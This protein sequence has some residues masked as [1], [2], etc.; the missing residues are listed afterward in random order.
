MSFTHGWALVFFSMLTSSSSSA[1]HSLSLLSAPF[2]HLHSI[3]FLSGRSLLALC[4]G[5]SH[6]WGSGS[7]GILLLPCS[8]A[9]G[10]SVGRLGERGI[11]QRR[12]ERDA[13]RY[14]K[15]SSS[16]YVM[17]LGELTGWGAESM[18]GLVFLVGS[19][20]LITPLPGNNGKRFIFVIGNCA[21][22]L[23][24]WAAPVIRAK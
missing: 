19:I 4:G 14:V 8:V 17:I 18:G 3:S 23:N 22:C 21:L 15:G 6:M 11:G 20:L 7:P 1:F 13:V 5:P 16:I 2:L 12:S 10:G 24:F 9:D